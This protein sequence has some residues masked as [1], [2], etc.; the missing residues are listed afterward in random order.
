MTRALNLR[1]ELR[2][3]ASG[4]LLTLCS[5]FGQTYYIALFAGQLRAEFAL[6]DGEFGGLYTLGTLGS[7]VVLV[8]AGKLADTVPIRWLGAGVLAGLALT[9]VAMAAVASPAMLAFVLFGLRFFGQG[10]LTHTA[11]TAMGRWFV[12]RRGRA[13]AIAALGLPA[14]EA[15]L[16]PLAVATVVLIGWRMSW[17][18]AALVLTFVAIPVFITLLTHERHPTRGPAAGQTDAATATRRQWTRGEV[19]R[20]PLYYGVLFVVLAPPFVV[21]AVFFNQVGLSEIKDWPLA[22]FAASFPLLAATH[23]VAALG[24]GWLIDRIGSHRLLA[25]FLLPLGLASLLLALLESAW[26]LPVAM[27]LIG[28]TLGG[29]SAT[30]GALWAELYGT[31]HLGAIRAV[32]TAA[33]VLSTAVAPGLVGLLL[34]AGVALETQLIAMTAYCLGAAVWMLVLLPALNR[35][36][37]VKPAL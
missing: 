4:F 36:A 14:A 7:A 33:V 16:P 31:L 10:M 20:S 3:L 28:L 11:M 37:D 9:S 8:F 5:G 23:V 29:A 18:A 26:V 30:Q 34:D 35:L 15:L 25:G 32:T 13:V 1:S 17:I 2:W 6:S 22:W 12:R 27:A 24:A 19:V 21:T